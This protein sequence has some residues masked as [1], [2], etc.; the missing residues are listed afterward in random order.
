VSEHDQDWPPIEIPAP[1]PLPRPA[2]EACAWDQREDE[3]TDA[4]LAFGDWL[5]W[6]GR[7]PYPWTARTRRWAAQYRWR[8]RRAAYAPTLSAASAAHEKAEEIGARHAVALADAFALAHEALLTIDA[9]ALAKRPRDVLA[10]LTEVAAFERLRAGEP[11]AIVR[12]DL[13]R[14]SDDALD[15]LDKALEE[16]ERQAGKRPNE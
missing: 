6:D 7:E 11:G 8:G 16:I 13:G 3:D 1:P 15:D 9:K 4:F 10:F 2:P 5:T 12:A 14:V